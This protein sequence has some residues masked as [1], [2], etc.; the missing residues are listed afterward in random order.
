MQRSITAAC[1]LGDANHRREQNEAATAFI[2]LATMSRE[3]SAHSWFDT[4][5]LLIVLARSL[6]FLRRAG[7]AAPQDTHA[8]VWPPRL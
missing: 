7:Y 8:N 3:V 5:L 4:M 2:P 1:G 6:L